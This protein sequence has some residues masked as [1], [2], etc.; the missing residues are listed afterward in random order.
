MNKARI[1]EKPVAVLGGGVCA[2]T[3]AA[4]FTL[5]GYKVRL[6][7]LLAITVSSIKTGRQKVQKK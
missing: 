7:E 3:F 2:Q 5:E 4:E 1:L 6:Y